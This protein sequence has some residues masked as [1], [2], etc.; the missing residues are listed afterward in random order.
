MKCWAGVDDEWGGDSAKGQL[1]PV[2]QAPA[3]AKKMTLA[4]CLCSRNN[5]GHSHLPA[6]STTP[7]LAG[8][9]GIHPRIPGRAFGAGNPGQRAVGS[10]RR[11]A[12]TTA[13][14]IAAVRCVRFTGHNV[15][16]NDNQLQ[17]GA[18]AIM[19]QGL[20]NSRRLPRSAAKLSLPHLPVR[21]S[22][23]RW[24]RPARRQSRHPLLARVF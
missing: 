6:G 18:A 10:C 17:T 19:D 12:P 13:R 3:A 21:T 20:R 7:L 14:A 11:R 15:Y 1:G 8:Q 16:W 2:R 24:P 9:G 4:L 5:S 23:V 22:L